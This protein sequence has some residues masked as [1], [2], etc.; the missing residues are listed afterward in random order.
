MDFR[1]RIEMRKLQNVEQFILF[2]VGVIKSGGM[3]CE[4]WKMCQGF[5]K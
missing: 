1:Q 2:A 3:R 4:T 5:K